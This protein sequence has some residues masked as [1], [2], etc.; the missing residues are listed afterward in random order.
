MSV[1][2]V[3]LTIGGAGI[4][5]WWTYAPIGQKLAA[6]AAANVLYVPIVL[7]VWRRRRGVALGIAAFAI[8]DCLPVVFSLLLFRGQFL[9]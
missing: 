4:L 1:S 8:A 2:L 5:R 6:I 3:L 9:R 7:L